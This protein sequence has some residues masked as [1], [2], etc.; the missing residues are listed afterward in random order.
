[1]LPAMSL[2]PELL[3]SFAGFGDS[4]YPGGLLERSVKELV[5]LQSSHNNT[6]PFCTIPRRADSTVGHRRRADKS[7]T[8]Q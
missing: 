8:G 7:F 3:R 6:C 4:V 1:M 2:R 5:I